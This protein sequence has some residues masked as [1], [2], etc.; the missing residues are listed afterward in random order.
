MTGHNSFLFFESEF[1][2]FIMEVKALSAFK[3]LTIHARKTYFKSLLYWYFINCKLKDSRFNDLLSLPALVHM[4]FWLWLQISCTRYWFLSHYYFYWQVVLT[5]KEK[6]VGYKLRLC[7]TVL[8]KHGLSGL[9]WSR[10]P[11]VR[12]SNPLA[13]INSLSLDVIYLRVGLRYLKYN[14]LIKLQTH[15]WHFVFSYISF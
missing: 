12:L 10:P 4:M 11:D 7:L 5:G 1:S 3:P 8:C 2:S 13:V 6:A 14:Q 15:S 9:L